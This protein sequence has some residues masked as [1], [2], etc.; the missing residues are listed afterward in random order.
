MN[1]AQVGIFKQVDEVCFRCLHVT[2]NEQANNIHV[3]STS[4]Y[5]IQY[6]ID[7][8]SLVPSLQRKQNG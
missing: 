1:S 5:T 2:T 7:V 4:D 6:N 3:I 8:V